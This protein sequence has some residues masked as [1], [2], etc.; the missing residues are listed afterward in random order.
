MLETEIQKLTA[1]IE[2][3]IVAMEGKGSAPIAEAATPTPAVPVQTFVEEV[4]MGD[5]LQ[6][7]CLTLVKKDR[8]NRDAIKALI[9]QHSNGGSLLADVPV[10]SYAAL[11]A[12][13]DAL[14]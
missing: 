7:K 14:K 9:A 12:A 3:L 1:A 8:A 11:G 4:A 5:D 10:T 6:K 13:L 2:R